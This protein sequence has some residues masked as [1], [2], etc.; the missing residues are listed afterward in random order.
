MHR[1]VPDHAMRVLAVA[2][3]RDRSAVLNA[4]AAYM[5]RVDTE[6]SVTGPGILPIPRVRANRA[7]DVTD[8]GGSCNSSRACS[9]GRW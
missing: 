6:S 1:I 9:I 2:S 7:S 8:V 3:C 5:E 4:L